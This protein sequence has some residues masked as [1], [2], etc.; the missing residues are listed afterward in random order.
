MRFSVTITVTILFL[1]VAGV[2]FYLI[3]SQDRPG[4]VSDEAI[5]MRLLPQSEEGPIVLIEI[6][7]LRKR[8]NVILK[9]ETQGWALAYPVS[10]P[11]DDL[12]VE[13]LVTAL[14]LSNKTKRMKPEKN[15]EEY[16]LARPDL[17]V[18]V[19]IERGQE[20]RTLHVGGL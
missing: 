7:N 11:A 17:K 10:Y 18:G 5:P 16:G 2:Y 20:R 12:I 4:P 8:E 6:Q 3:P 9:R 13:G 14:R 1:T 19:E 15:W